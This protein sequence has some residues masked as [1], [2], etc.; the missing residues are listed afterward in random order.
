MKKLSQFFLILFSFILLIQVESTA[1]DIKELQ[2]KPNDFWGVKWGDSPDKLGGEKKLIRE[3]KEKHIAVYDLSPKNAFFNKYS[4]EKARY[5]FLHNQ[6]I[7]IK[8]YFQNKPIIDDLL[9][10]FEGLF[11]KHTLI[12]KKP[13]ETRYFW[14]DNELTIGLIIHSKSN[15]ALDI[16]N[17]PLA[18]ELSSK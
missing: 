6:F 3:N 14:I 2:Y 9:S 1:Y 16:L 4:V 18:R 5:L 15:W 8:I 10:D 11:G 13:S 7:S 12:D 17:D